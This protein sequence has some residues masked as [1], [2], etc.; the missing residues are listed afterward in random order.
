MKFSGSES[1]ISLR[2]TY[3]FGDGILF[4]VET[5]IANCLILFLICISLLILIPAEDIGMFQGICSLVENF[6]FPFN[7]ANSS[8]AEARR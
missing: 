6:H 1:H 5:I 4:L 7:R 8:A 2:S 3:R